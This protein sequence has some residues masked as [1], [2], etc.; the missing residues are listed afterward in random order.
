MRSA[1]LYEPVN[2]PRMSQGCLEARDVLG[3]PSTATNGR[4]RD[5]M[6]NN[7]RY[8]KLAP[9]CKQ[10]DKNFHFLQPTKLPRINGTASKSDH[11]CSIS[12]GEVSGNL[13]VA[14]DVSSEVDQ[15]SCTASPAEAQLPC[16]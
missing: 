6:P 4:P 12:A 2:A 10:T 8:R 3:M 9:S 13:K 16:I 15:V 11:A 7:L 5:T 14:S 1:G